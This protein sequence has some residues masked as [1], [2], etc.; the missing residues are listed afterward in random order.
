MPKDGLVHPLLA[1][2]PALSLWRAPTDNDRIGGMAARWAAWGIEPLERR[3]LSVDR[4]GTATVV[5]SEYRTG[6]GIPVP[7]EVRYTAL[8][9][10]GVR[11]EESVVIPDGLTDLPR[12]GTVLEVAG[13]L[14]A[15][16]VVRFRPARDLPRP[17]AR[18]ADRSLALVG[19]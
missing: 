3:L 10:G 18:R 8:A 6:A 13:D 19:R 5:R 9:G 4:D 12:V 16:R 15:R 1:A 11:V 7:H 17:E 2:P 14:G